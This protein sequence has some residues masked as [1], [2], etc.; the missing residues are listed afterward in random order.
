MWQPDGWGETRIGFLTPH[1]DIVPEAEFSAL[2]PDGISIHATRIPFGGYKPGG[3]MDPTIAD[4]PVRAIADPL[5]VDDAAEMLAMAPL[6]ED[7]SSRRTR[8]ARRCAGSA[9][10]VA[11]TLPDL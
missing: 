5:A 11:L 2:A 7:G 6:V 9:W 4:A 10:R 8:R 1:A 3:T